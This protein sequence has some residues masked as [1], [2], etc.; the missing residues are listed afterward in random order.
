MTE[1]KYINKENDNKLKTKDLIT[2]GLYTLLLILL[3]AVGLGVCAGVFSVLF[4]GKLYF[5][6][7]TTV[8]TGL[9]AAPAY[10]LIFNKI[11]KDYAVFIAAFIIGVFLLLSGHPY[12]AFPITILGGLLAEYFFRKNNEYL[13]YIFFTLGGLGAL[14]PM[15]FMRDSYIEHLKARG[16]SPEKID[17]VMSNSSMNI[18][19]VVVVLTIVFSALGT[20]IGRKLYFRNFD[21]AGL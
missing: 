20:Y 2:L 13:S 16:F 19:I 14:M 21:K 15:Y 10:T 6:V 5:S 7:F 18:F 11:K 9:F 8:A 1:L 3:M 12:I 4:A 17:F